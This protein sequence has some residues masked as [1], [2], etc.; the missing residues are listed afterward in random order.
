MK[1]KIKFLSAEK[2]LKLTSGE[3]VESKLFNTKTLLPIP[4][5]LFCEKIFG[6][7]EDYTCLCTKEKQIYRRGYSCPR[8]GVPF[9]RT[10]LRRTRTGYVRL[11]TPHVHPLAIPL[12]AQLF[13]IDSQ[14]FKQVMRGDAWILWEIDPEAGTLIIRNQR[15]KIR[16]STKC[17]DPRMERSPLGLYL[18]TEQID[19][20]KTYE[21]YTEM[22][23]KARKGD[24][25]K[26]WRRNARFLGHCL[27]ENLR[28]T[29]LFITLLPVIPPDLRPVLLKGSHTIINP[30][31]ELYSNALWRKLRLH[32]TQDPRWSNYPSILKKDLLRLAAASSQIALNERL[33]DGFKDLHHTP[34]KSLL[35]D[36]PGKKGHFRS[37]ML[38]KRVDY[39]ARTVITPG[40]QLTLNEVGI[41]RIMAVQLFNPWIVGFLKDQYHY[42]T[43]RIRRLFKQDDPLLYDVLTE[44]VK[45]KVVIM[46]RQ[47]TLHRLGML[48]FNIHLHDGKSLLLHPMVCGVFNADFD[49]DQMAVHVPIS[50]EGLEETKRLMYPSENLL[51][52]ANSSPV[53]LPSHELVIGLNDLTCIREGTSHCYLT[54]ERAKEEYYREIIRINDPVEICTPARFGGGKYLTCVGRLILEDVLGIPITQPLTKNLLKEVVSLSYDLIGKE[55]LVKALDFI[56]NIAYTHVTQ[57][58]FSLGMKDFISPSM[59]EHR[60]ETAQQY[61]SDLVTQHHTGI[62]TENECQERK[63][64]TWMETIETLQKDFLYEA[65]KRNPLVVMLETGA[66]VSMTQVSQ[67]IVAKG[68]QASSNG[69][70]IEDPILHSLKTG[71]TPH[72]FFLSCYGAR[73]SMSDK[74][75]VTPLSGYLARR[76][77][78]AAGDLYISE[79]DC[80][81]T[82]EGVELQ[83]RY[84]AGRLTCSGE[85]INTNT[86]QE[87][88][89]VRSPI[90]CQAKKGI[91]ATCY[92]FDP[93]KRAQVT[94]GTPIGIIAAQSLTEPCTQLSMRSFHT[95]GVAELKDSSLVVRARL[96]GKVSFENDPLN[97]FLMKLYIDKE[98][99]IVHR[100]NVRILVEEG[101]HVIIGDPLVVYTSK[102]LLNQDIGGKLLLLERYYELGMTEKHNAK[103]KYQNALIAKEAGIVEL[104]IQ[105][106]KTVNIFIN[107]KTQ[108]VVHDI[109]IF[110]H[111]RQQVRQGEFLTYGEAN[112]LDYYVDNLACV[113]NVFVQR[114]QHL[115][116]EEGIT[117][118]S[119]HF[120][121]IF[122]SMTELVEDTEG[123]MG[124]FREGDTGQRKLLG[125]TNVGRLYPSWLKRISFGHIKEGLEKA[126]AGFEV[127][128]DLPS[129][130]LLYTQF[131]L[132]DIPEKENEIE[133]RK[134]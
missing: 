38:G 112:L 33:I 99:Y 108:G 16:I 103:R 67:L 60:V 18:L 31:N 70:I 23:E 12:F 134:V 2:I 61:V 55:N 32:Y 122:R 130:R 47:P 78:N 87:Y 86:S 9:M 121:M 124:L 39:S 81:Y 48:C 93:A 88:I 101:Q 128:R 41:P 43:N 42:T 127:S 95:S 19:L 98:Y 58:G 59:L 82:T 118:A 54:K 6:P 96:A 117:S 51:S 24:S 40:P 22:I 79:Q 37:K 114:M 129:E 68:I 5:G 65:G 83:K 85:R 115:Y 125:I 100:N 46:N 13:C 26:D 63:I 15:H 72:E 36:L 71:L 119:V 94:L 84:A 109:P 27:K 1:W 30:K 56:K 10:L 75:M 50:I 123:N 28:L 34:M 132:F 110:V 91:C 52:P 74:K 106:E 69:K 49:G 20:Q 89:T 76:L 4:N 66:R 131:P 21:L 17:N 64:R 3:V 80:G 120:D 102:N 105:E 126:A 53:I 62:I 92:G 44:V 11:A 25:T 116:E 77:V 57:M 73:K 113:S 133:E 97:A 111:S 29:D 45:D 7:L 8:C 90:F 104:Q 107:G 35:Q 14:E